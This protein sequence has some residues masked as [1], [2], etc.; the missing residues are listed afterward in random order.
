MAYS[1]QHVRFTLECD[2]CGHT[3]KR[4][5]DGSAQESDGVIGWAMVSSN[6]A[7]RFCCPVCL[8]S[9]EAV[10]NKKKRAEQEAVLNCVH[11]YHQ[12]GLLMQCTKCRCFKV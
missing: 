12:R 11:N 1:V 9:V 2:A 5:L 4:D 8:D 6:L 3:E 7:S 10:L